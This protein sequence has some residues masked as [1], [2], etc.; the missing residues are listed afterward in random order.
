MA[1][2]LGELLVATGQ[3]TTEQVE[4]ALRTQIIWGGRLGSVLVEQNLIDLDALTRALASQLQMPAALA[5]HF[6]HALP[7]LQARLP[8]EIAGLWLCIPIT[9]LPGDEGRLAIAVARPLTD[10]AQL[11]IATHLGVTP[12]HLMVGIAAELRIRYHLERAY[13]IV[14]DQRYLRSRAGRRTDPPTPT[15]H[16]AIE[17][18]SDDDFQSEQSDVYEVDP[19]APTIT[20]TIVP[21]PSREIYSVSPNEPVTDAKANRRYMSTLA[22]DS[23]DRINIPTN[24]SDRPALGRI[25]IR[26][27][28]MSPGIMTNGIDETTGGSLEEATRAI[29]RATDR[30]RVADLA[31]T[32]L[33]R[34]APGIHTLAMFILRGDVAIGWKAQYLQQD[35]SA[36]AVNLVVPLDTPNVIATASSEG[37]T[38]QKLRCDDLQTDIDRRLVEAFAPLAA[39]P[40]QA[41]TANTYLLVAPIKIKTTP[42]CVMVALASEHTSATSAGFDAVTAAVSTAFARLIHAARR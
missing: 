42:A 19:P 10:A 32:A 8:A 39:A 5:Q 20:D 24:D 9:R 18:I 36:V 22:D 37:A 26:K 15:L 2:R 7:E 35:A 25:A 1:V 38:A 27:A 41:A 31:M 33:Q 17:K 28:A 12:D 3:L 21:G 16:L 4:Q 40:N 14:R 23:R 30:D 6:E 29:R 34:F 11:E 13:G